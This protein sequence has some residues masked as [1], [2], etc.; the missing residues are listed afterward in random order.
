MSAGERHAL[1][2]GATGFIGRHL[3]L[4]LGRAGVRV[5]AA[6]RT[7]ES[8]RRLAR[9]LAD[10]GSDGVPA[11]LRV[12]FSSPALIEEDCDDVTEVYNSAGAF[13]F[14]MSPREAR[15]AN[16]DSVR[17]VVAFAARLPRLRRLVQV[18]GYRVSGQDTA[19][20]S[21]ERR[22]ETYRTLGAYEASKVEADGVFRAEAER[23]GVPWSVVNPATVI[24]DS[25]TGES[26]QYLGLASSLKDLWRGALPALP[27]NARTFVPVVTVDHLARFMTR[28]PVDDAAERAA[29]WLLDDDTPALPDLLSLVAD[30][31]QVGA[32]GARIPVPLLKRLPR[33]LT[34]ADPET[35]TFLSSDRYPTG[36][37]HAFA[38]RHGLV[39]PDTVTAVRRWADHLAA[40]RFG[41]APAG[42]R[43]FT[44]PAG[45]RTFELGAPD[46]PTV[47][48][49]GLP[50]NAD[51]WAPVV[52]AL[53]HA[54]A[55]DLPGLGMSAGRREDWPSWLSALVTGT[56][57]RH[58]VGHSIGAA[59]AVE[60][61]AAHPGEVE[62]LTLVA[63]FFLQARPPRAVR[64]TPLTRG[65]LRRVPPGALARRLAGDAAPATALRTSA[66]DLRRG[67]AAATARLLA[68]TADPREREKLRAGLRRYEGSVHV[69][70]GSRDP[71]TP[72]GRALLD[73][74]PRA[75]VTVVADAGHH[76]QLT[77]PEE[78]AQAVQAHLHTPAH[79]TPK[80]F[81]GSPRPA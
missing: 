2:F 12:D 32:P 9:W 72:E 62:R 63:P 67:S 21:E 70:V 42:R 54:R 71:L 69:I 73:A 18:S 43:R 45:V 3:V 65:Y 39:A 27:G 50:A 1:V 31:W 19:P 11:G 81:Q 47:V 33:W 41:D 49:P 53:G 51:T 38:A 16:V 30:H 15:H 68:V 10:R 75:T 66:A 25:A 14:G 5:S 20:W 77:H 22:R 7:P 26:D 60:A 78:V 61:A 79:D 35:L 56:G 24:G 40:H 74:L 52:A 48:L 80:T 17:S 46:A 23:L 58:L 44:S 55:V 29:Y 6:T 36:S 64:W 28:L 34:R 37:A 59:A 57:A 76:P 8:H 4:E 13:R